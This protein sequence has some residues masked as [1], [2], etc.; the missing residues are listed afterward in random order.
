MKVSKY[1]RT[2][3]YRTSLDIEFDPNDA[4]ELNAAYELL[5]AYTNVRG[6]GNNA[7]TKPGV[8]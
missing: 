6:L 8:E 4:A 3:D 7:D 5:A 2:G 1:E